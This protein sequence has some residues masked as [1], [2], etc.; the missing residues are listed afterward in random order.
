MYLRSSLRPVLSYTLVA[1]AAVEPQVSRAPE[2][3]NRVGEDHV[4]PF[5]IRRVG[6]HHDVGVAGGLRSERVL[7]VEAAE[8]GAV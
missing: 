5:A 3:H 8:H 2:I 7:L 1:L 6:P 4:Q